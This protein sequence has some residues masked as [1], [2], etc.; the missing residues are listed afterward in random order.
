MFIIIITIFNTG[1]KASH[2]QKLEK[3]RIFQQASGYSVAVSQIITVAEYFQGW[4]T[5]V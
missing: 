2:L 4:G 5:R 3:G 1:F